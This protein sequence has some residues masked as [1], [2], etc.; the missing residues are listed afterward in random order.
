[1]QRT[2]PV[3]AKAAAAPFQVHAYGTAQSTS[4]ESSLLQARLDGVCMLG[5]V[6]LAGDMVPETIAGKL[7]GGLCASIGVVLLAIP[8]GIFISGNDAGAARVALVL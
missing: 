4:L 5:G 8:A 2:C 6:R 7:I 1:M 3:D